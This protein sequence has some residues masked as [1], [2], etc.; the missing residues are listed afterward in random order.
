M[1]AVRREVLA[2]LADDDDRIEE[3]ADRLDDRHQ[4]LDVRIRRVALIRRRLDAIDRQRREQQRRATERVAVTADDS[5]AV[6]VNLLGEAVDV[7]AA[8]LACLLRAEP[9]G[10]GSDF[11]AADRLFAWRHARMIPLLEGNPIHSGWQS[12]CTRSPEERC[13]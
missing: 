6:G 4:P 7:G 5:A 13:V 10:C 11:L 8:G 2:A 3:P 12:R 1:V 9:D